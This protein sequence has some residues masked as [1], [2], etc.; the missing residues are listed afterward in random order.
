MV[1]E[2]QESA[3]LSRRFDELA[4][5][6]SVGIEGLHRRLSVVLRSSQGGNRRQ[7]TREVVQ[8]KFT[9]STTAGPLAGHTID[10]SSGGALLA[11]Q[12]PTDLTGT[13]LTLQLD[14]IGTL[15]ANVQAATELGLHLH[16]TSVSEAQSAA[17]EQQLQAV[18][19]QHVGLT[20]R[21]AAIAVDVRS[22]LERA[23]ADGS[24]TDEQ[25]LEPSYREVPDTAPQQFVTTYTDLCERVLAPVL[26]QVKA[27]D[28]QVSFCIVTDRNG[29]VPVHNS[30]YSKPQRPGEL[31][32]NT[33]NCRNRQFFE[34]RTGI[35]AARNRLPQLVQA[36]KRDMG[37]GREVM[38]KEINV[39]I[40]IAGRHWGGVRLGLTL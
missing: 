5:G 39:P 36:Y 31:G 18:R 16:F 14:K 7:T 10:L 25:L 8:L 35:L 40:E 24:I 9:A 17:I 32:W 11:V 23:I 21:C 20:E 38:V 30:D 28:P 13:S 4:N 15:N 26:E 37:D 3:A 27:G 2:A 6:V 29:Y 34:D 1:V 22:R 19:A 12:P 33:A